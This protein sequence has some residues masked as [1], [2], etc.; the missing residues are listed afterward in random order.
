[1]LSTRASTALKLATTAAPRRAVAARTLTS[2]NTRARTSPVATQVPSART[3]PR[4]SFGKMTMSSAAG[5]GE[6]THRPEPDQVLK[7]WWEAIIAIWSGTALT[8]VILL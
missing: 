6:S 1:M 8:S 3:I 2:L 7:G 5:F 4:P